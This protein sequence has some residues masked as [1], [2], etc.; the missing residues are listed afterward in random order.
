MSA[1]RLSHSTLSRSGLCAAALAA[2]VLAAGISV[3]RPAAGAEE[4]GRLF[5]TPQ[6]R[7]EL[8][9][10][11][12]TNTQAA[13]AAVTSENLITING[14]VSRSSGKSTTWINGQPQDDMPQGRDPTTVKLS[15]GENEPD[16]SLR[17]GQTHLVHGLFRAGEIFQ[18]LGIRIL[19]IR[20][21]SFMIM[22]S[23][24]QNG[25]ADSSIYWC[26]EWGVLNHN[27]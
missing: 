17:V 14:R 13:A 18:R 3:S 2:L 1:R 19:M 16:I 10:R 24:L 11:R 26:F 8:E 23:L 27:I 12:A 15:P 22:G 7:Q 21:R 9:R 4:L 6:Q 20:W 5:L 25:A